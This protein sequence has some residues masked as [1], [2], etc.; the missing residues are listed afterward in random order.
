MKLAP[1]TVFRI[2]LAAAGLGWFGWT[3][4]HPGGLHTDTAVPSTASDEAAATSVPQK[5]HTWQLGSL[6]L[7]ACELP[8]PHTGL[9]SAAWCAPFEVPENRADPHSRKIG[10]NLAVVRSA[11][12]DGKAITL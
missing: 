5:P 3:Y 2:V 10:L 4:F 11:A 6:T 9:S 7:T 8:Q 1:R 12:Q